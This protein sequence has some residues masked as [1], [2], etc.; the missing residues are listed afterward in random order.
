MF[1]CE[2]ETLP[3]WMMIDV[4]FW[5]LEV[6]E[7]DNNYEGNKHNEL[8]NSVCQYACVDV[9]SVNESLKFF[10]AKFSH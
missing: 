10:P 5:C 9:I 3:H 2:S 6:R 4:E 1:R 7:D 8:E